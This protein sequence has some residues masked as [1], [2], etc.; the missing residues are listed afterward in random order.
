MFESALEQNIPRRQLGRGAILSIAAHGVL[1][2]LALYL[3]SRPSTHQEALRTVTFFNPPPPP[4]PPPPPAGGGSKA[5]KVEPKKI[6]K[7][8]DTVVETKK[9]EKVPE[10]APDPSPSP[11]PAGQVGGVP[12]GVAGGVVGGVVG[13]TLGGVVGGTGNGNEVLPFGAG[14]VKP[15]VVHPPEITFSK[16]ARAMR[17]GGLAL[18]E[19]VINLDGSVSDCRVT[20]S[21]PYMDGQL[22][23]AA[24][25]MRYTPVMYQGHPQ[26]VKMVFPIRV[27]TPS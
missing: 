26:R 6:I 14:M 5:K 16:E 23:Q 8:P 9:T 15:S 12:G 17:V 24:R 27:P 11:D 10:K 20:K 25:S 4:P 22:L 2:G 13:G 18:V 21:L 3:S 19:C 7:K 1:I